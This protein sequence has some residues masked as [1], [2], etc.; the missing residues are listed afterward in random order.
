MDRKLPHLSK[1]LAALGKNSKLQ[2][3][4][5]YTAKV[6]VQLGAIAGGGLVDATNAVETADAA[7]KLGDKVA[8]MTIASVGYA[9]ELRETG[10][11][12]KDL[13]NS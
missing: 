10:S 12:I 9:D 5:N 3:G 11:M 8:A 1:A 6:L 7:V 4:V 13:A 2:D